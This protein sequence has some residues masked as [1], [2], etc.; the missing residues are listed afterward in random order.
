MVEIIR[1][2]DDDQ[3]A[4][5]LHHRLAAAEQ[6][7][8]ADARVSLCLPGGSTPRPV[9]QALAGMPL[10][11]SRVAIW[12]GDDRCVPVDHPA[13]NAGM[14]AAAL[15]KVGADIV[16]L[17]EDAVPPRFALTWL[18]MGDDGHVASLFPETDPQ[19]DDPQAIRRITPDP[20]PPHAPFDRITLTL[21]ALLATGEVLFVI[22]GEQK[23]ALFE[24]AVAGEIDLP[25]ARLLRS[26]EAQGIPVTCF[27]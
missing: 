27:A 12:P 7:A 23:L 4:A 17:A 24:A 25:V 21:P 26:A 9:L 2:A 6:A 14:I 22:R 16:P 8:P 10:D 19:A 5:W 13:S 3:V 11:W 1:N 20:L 15:G 18:G